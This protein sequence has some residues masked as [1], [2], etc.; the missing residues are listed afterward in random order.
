MVSHLLDTSDVDHDLETLI[1]EKTEGVPFF[2]EEF[3]KSLKNL[4]IIEKK[5]SRF[6]LSGG[7]HD[8][9]IPNTIQD[10]I[11][12]RVDSL[13]QGAKEVLQ[14]GSA[15]EREFSHK[16]MQQVAG[17]P[18]QELLS[19]LSVLKDA[20]LLFERG[21]YPEST[22]IFKHALTREVIYDSILNKRKKR[23]HEKIGRIIEYIYAE[24]LEEFYEILAHHYSKSDNSEKAYHYLK[25]AGGKAIR[26]NSNWEAF[27][28][29][30]EAIGILNQLPETEENKREQIRIRLL[31][32]I[33]MRLLGY[34]RDL[35]QILRKGERFSRELGDKRSLANFYGSISNFYA[36]KGDSQHGIKY[37]EK[38]YNEAKKI[39]KIELM[40]PIAVDLCVS[41]NR[42]GE[43]SKVIDFVPNVLDLLEKTQRK[44]ETFGRPFNV[45]CSL[46]I[47]YGL[48]MGFLGN[49]EQGKMLCQKSLEYALEINDSYWMAGAELFYGIVCALKGEI[50]NAIA[51][52]RNSIRFSEEL[53]TSSLTGFSRVG[54]L[55]A[56]RDRNSP[57]AYRK[58]P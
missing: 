23:L 45:Y 37:A 44:H 11:M 38:G 7:I 51:H 5:E 43:F 41:Y 29:F 35:L 47:H 28:I 21:I 6:H 31:M 48:S 9:T 55:F 16:L 42:V 25:V 8:L 32:A 17:F 53:Q 52:L 3:I 2:V 50:K 58:R 10:V 20:E 1:L 19:Y 22:Y 36:F 14:R 27:R 46:H 12:A 24:Q 26:N 34:P 13:P 33:P 15:I 49:F 56:G 4:Q 54:I 57:K 18:E 39:Q 30:K 40:A